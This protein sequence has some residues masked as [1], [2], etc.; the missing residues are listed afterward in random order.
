V[1]EP[2]VAVNTVPLPLPRPVSQPSSKE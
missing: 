1:R 2:A